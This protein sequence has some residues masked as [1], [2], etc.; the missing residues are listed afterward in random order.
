MFR[1][2]NFIAIVIV[3]SNLTNCLGA[4]SPHKPERRKGM[5]Y[6]L[7]FGYEDRPDEWTKAEGNDIRDI[8]I[9]FFRFI[10]HT[11]IEKPA[12]LYIWNTLDESVRDPFYVTLHVGDNKISELPE[13]VLRLGKAML[14]IGPEEG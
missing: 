14:A 11:N 6:E 13:E 9:E 1:M 10:E 12:H 8:V 4:I 3:T 2:A 7:L 5:L